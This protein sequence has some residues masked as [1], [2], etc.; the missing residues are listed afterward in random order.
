MAD[1]PEDRLE[2]APPFTY[3]AVDLFGS[4]HIK[5]GRKELKRYGVLFMCMSSRA[6][7]LET[8]NSLETDSFIQSLRPFIDRRGPVR[9]I[10]CD[11]GTIFVGAK[12]ELGDQLLKM[13]QSRVHQ[14]L[15]ERDCDWIEFQFNVPSASHMGGIWECQI[16]TARN[17]LAVLLDQCGTQL[18]DESLRTV[19]TEAEA[20]LNSR[21]LTVE[22]RSSPDGVEP[23][24]PNH[25]PTGKSNVVLPP[26]GVFQRADVY[27]RKR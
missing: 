15:L 24:T 4:F 3:C 9:Q 14:F 19:M 8:A 5:E 25:W 22:S 16:R 27:L 7:H 13:D 2:P 1:L 10:R 12:R 11:Q 6:I 17:V 18:D 21:P 20:I 26:P 23:L